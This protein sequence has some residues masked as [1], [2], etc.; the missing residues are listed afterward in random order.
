MKPVSDLGAHRDFAWNTVMWASGN[1]KVKISEKYATTGT[2]KFQIFPEASADIIFQDAEVQ[3]A[4]W[5]NS[6]GPCK[7]HTTRGIFDVSTK[8]IVL[9]TDLCSDGFCDD[10]QVGK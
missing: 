5:S 6:N 9:Q 8:S 2:G 1:T 4:G 7:N 3:S 10:N